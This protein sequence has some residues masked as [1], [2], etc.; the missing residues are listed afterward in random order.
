LALSSKVLLFLRKKCVTSGSSSSVLRYI[1]IACSPDVVWCLAVFLIILGQ[2]VLSIDCHQPILVVSGGLAWT[3]FKVSCSGG[4][5]GVPFWTDRTHIEGARKPERAELGRV[6]PLF[7]PHL[8]L[9]VSAHSIRASGPERI[10]MSW[11]SCFSAA[12][13]GAAAGAAG[14]PVTVIHL[15]WCDTRR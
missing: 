1:I 2:L 5:G 14:S 9:K 12:S 10:L 8:V 4:G 3:L 13:W 6:A 11:C 7:R 15:A